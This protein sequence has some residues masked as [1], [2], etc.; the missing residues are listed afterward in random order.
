M[1][2]EVSIER[3]NGEGGKSGWR[4]KGKGMKEGGED[5]GMGNEEV[6]ENEG[7]RGW[8][9]EGGGGMREGGGMKGRSGTWKV[10]RHRN[11]VCLKMGEEFGKSGGIRCYIQCVYS[12][13][14]CTDSGAGEEEC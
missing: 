14:I 9:N 11:D 3:G 10:R 1:E 5:E 4:M 8:G 13:L 2:E 7:M 12:V 6:W